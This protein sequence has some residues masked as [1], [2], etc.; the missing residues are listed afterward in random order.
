MPARKVH[1]GPGPGEDRLEEDD[2]EGE[3]D[4]RAHDRVQQEAIEASRERVFVRSCTGRLAED[5][6]GPG[7]AVRDAARERNLVAR[8]LL[9]PR[10]QFTEITDTD[11]ACADD[12]DDGDAERVLQLE[13]VD[14]AAPGLELVDH[15][16]HEHGGAADRQD[17]GEQGQAALE[18]RR[19]DDAYDAVRRAFGRDLAAQDTDRDRLV[20]ADRVQAVCAGQVDQLD[21]ARA[22]HQLAGAAF[23]GDAGVV[24][25]LGAQARQ[26]VE[27]RRLARVGAAD[28]GDSARL[29]QRRGRGL[30][31]GRIRQGREA[32]FR[33]IPGSGPRIMSQA[34]GPG[35][36]PSIRPQ[37]QS[38][39]ISTWIRLVSERR[40]HT[41]VPRKP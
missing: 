27:E 12:A 18:R 4:E 8:P 9:W 2:E 31:H 25:G 33:P 11:A 24:T 32:A 30:G 38:L 34:Q 3:E 29:R 5:A 1:R 14:V 20:F 15:R 39:K 16:Q 23:D 13:D 36:G 41:C 22:V 21:L 19:V 10:Q 6:V 37:D 28:E 7:E 35:S 40:R 17:L 26:G